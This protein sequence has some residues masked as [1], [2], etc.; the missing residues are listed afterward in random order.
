MEKLKEAFYSILGVGIFIAFVLI[1]GLLFIYGAKFAE[2]ILPFLQELTGWITAIAL[3]ILLP[4]A[5]FR[6]TRT[7]SAVGLYLSSFVFGISLWV[8]GFLTAYFYWGVVGVLIGLVF[9]GIGVVPVAI[10]AAL[11]NADWSTIGSIVYLIAITYGARALGIYFEASVNKANQN[12]YIELDALTEASVEKYCHAC[13]GGNKADS[14]F[15]KFC[16]E[17]Q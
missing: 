10:L 4:L 14:K 8:Y 15:C 5:I 12:E 3:F 1:T 9:L 17:K 16:G 7:I 2:A 13:G 6:Q 11:V